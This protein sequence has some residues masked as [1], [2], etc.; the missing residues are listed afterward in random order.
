M[1]AASDHLVL[2][3]R[4]TTKTGVESEL[5]R[6]IEDVSDRWLRRRAGRI[7]TWDL[8]SI[9]EGNCLRTFG[10]R[11]TGSLR[12]PIPHCVSVRAR[13]VACQ[14]S[15][16][17]R[18]IV[19]RGEQSGVLPYWGLCGPTPWQG[20]PVA[21]ARYQTGCGFRESAAWSAIWVWILAWP[22]GGLGRSV[23]VVPWRL[24]CQGLGR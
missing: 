7:Q 12:C 21:S 17:N 23:V 11:H 6:L 13:I 14:R 18:S 8:G 5:H 16:G 22:C 1:P 10:P 19:K 2:H 24:V 4:H 20:V 9:G 3:R 15:L